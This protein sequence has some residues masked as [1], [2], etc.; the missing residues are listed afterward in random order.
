MTVIDLDSIVATTHLWDPYE[1]SAHVDADPV[2]PINYGPGADF[3]QSDPTKRPQ[4]K[5]SGLGP[6]SM[7]Y[8]RFDGTNDVVAAVADPTGYPQTVLCIVRKRSAPDGT[9][10]NAISFGA[11]T[12]GSHHIGSFSSTSADGLI[13]YPNSSFAPVSAGGT[14]TSVQVVGFRINSAS[15][16]DVFS[17]SKTPVNLNP[18]DSINTWASL[19]LGAKWDGTEPGD[20]DFGAG[21]VWDSALSTGDLSEAYDLLVSWAAGDLIPET[22]D[23]MTLPTYV[24][25]AGG[26]MGPLDVHTVI[27]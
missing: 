22:P 19:G 27:G 21:A 23:V 10:R 12:D 5:S 16:L 6:G 4:W 24:K 2:I 1:D 9:P 11:S 18:P 20:F 26:F 13:Y 15:S 7:P 14:A 8:Y 3:L 17:G 25:L